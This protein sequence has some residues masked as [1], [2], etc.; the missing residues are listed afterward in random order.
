MSAAATRDVILRDGRTLRLRVPSGSDAAALDAF[1]RSLSPQSLYRRFHGVPALEPSFV[2]GLLDQDGVDR[3]ALLGTMTDDGRER[4][5][6]LGSF[7]RLRDPTV[8]E[9]A[10]A[11][12]DAFQGHGVGT[13]LLEQLAAAAGRVG[14]ETF[15]A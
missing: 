9:V 2:A 1:L 13:R 12:E 8:A 4:V 14:I 3:C 7:A 6:A 10:F 5:V 15:V 11:V